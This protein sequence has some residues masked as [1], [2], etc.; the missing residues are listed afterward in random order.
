MEKSQAKAADHI[1][2]KPIN[3]IVFVNELNKQEIKHTPTAIQ[4]IR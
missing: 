2:N 4:Y 1:Y 3:T